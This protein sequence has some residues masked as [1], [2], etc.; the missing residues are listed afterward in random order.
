MVSLFLFYSGYG[1]IESLKKKGYNYIIQLPKKSLILFIKF[2]IILLIFLFNNMILGKPF[3]FK[4]YALSIIFKQSLG[5]SNWFAFTIISLYLYSFISFVFIKNKK[6]FLV[7]ILFINII[8]FLHAFLTYNY[9]YPKSI[10]SVDNLLCFIIGIY[11]SI[12][13]QILDKIFMKSDILYFGNVTFIIIIYYYFYNNSYINIFYISITNGLFSLIII[14]ISMK[15]KFSNEFLIN[16]NNHSYSIY[17]LQRV[18]MIYI[19][20]KKLIND[21]EF[22]RF[23]IIFTSI[24]FISNIFDKYTSFIDRFLKPNVNSIIILKK[25]SF[26][27]DEE[28][29]EL[30]YNPSKNNM[31]NN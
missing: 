7:G 20:Q 29:R 11:Y 14:L 21:Y 26:G 16:L 2:Q 17:L 3:I 30:I 25:L 18:V 1:I 28:S 31:N 27:I 19:H 9:F 10:G 12:L 13:K 4:K 8:V 22:I 6:F 5:N 23:I 15:I 24:L